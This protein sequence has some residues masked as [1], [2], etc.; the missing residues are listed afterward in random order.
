MEYR[1]YHKDGSV[2]WLREQGMVVE[3][4]EEGQTWLDGFIFD[5]TQR[6]A[7]EEQLKEAKLQAE[8]AAAARS[9]FLANM[10][11]EI[12]T[13]MNA[14]IGFSDLMLDENLT[15][16]QR[17]HTVTINR[18]ARSLLH[19]L[20]DILDSAKL[21]KGKLELEY[22]DFILTDEVDTVVS[23]FWLEAKRKDLDFEIVLDESLEQAYHGVPERIRQVLG[24]LIGNA[25][26][27]TE[28]GKITLSIKPSGKERVAFRVTDTG[29]GMSAEQLNKVF[30]AFA[31][32][33]ASMSRRFGGTGLGTTISKQLV[34]LMKGDIHASSE[35]GKGTTFWFEIPLVSVDLENIKAKSIN[36]HV[37]PQH[38]LVVDDIQQNID[39]ISLLLKRHNH[40]L[41]IARN[42]VE[43]LAKMKEQTF[44]LVLMDLQMP[45]MDGLSASR[46]RRK[47]ERSNGARHIPIIALTASV[48]V[49]D[50]D[51]AKAAGM[52]GFAN[53]PVD[54]VQLNIEMGRVL[55]LEL[56]KHT[57]AVSRYSRQSLKNELINWDKGIALWG[58]KP[59]L[60][61]EVRRFL[62]HLEESIKQLAD[63]ISE[64]NTSETRTL[65]HTL[66][67]VAGNLALMS[68]MTLFNDAEKAAGDVKQSHQLLNQIGEEVQRLAA[69][70]ELMPDDK[71]VQETNL[72]IRDLKQKAK[73]LYQSVE[74]NRL[75]ESVLADIQLMTTGQYK[76]QI[77]AICTDIDDFEFDHAATRL[78]S[79]IDDLEQVAEEA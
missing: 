42:G 17:K 36:V 41:D 14:I 48:L 67:G 57:D 43:A 16:T 53:K 38:I 66:K 31:Q 9:A 32:A 60:I 35:L 69:L 40:T 52:E 2:R 6:R 46:E 28:G 22:R 72:D 51:D 5:I 76:A 78:A 4:K 65:S 47:F 7:M 63:F 8:Q 30:D 24:N 71:Q 3:N 1:I 19:L 20:N 39:L 37:P 27:F 70:P 26:K 34:E 49:Q 45:V 61:Q 11:H 12:R 23:T 25:V 74:Q 59:T 79:L 21:D 29:I 55:G 13:P 62:G 10:S 75:D 73:R 64:H 50:K 77:E 68:L 54:F 15:Q 44:D 58:D 33:D 18:S 56:P